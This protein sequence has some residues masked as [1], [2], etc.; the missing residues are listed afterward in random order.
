[1][2]EEDFDFDSSHAWLSTGSWSYQVLWDKA[3][4]KKPKN[5]L[6][7]AVPPVC[8]PDPPEDDN[9]AESKKSKRTSRPPRSS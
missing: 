9:A 1:M 6:G 5:P 8:K 3:R 7:F 2:S 4:P